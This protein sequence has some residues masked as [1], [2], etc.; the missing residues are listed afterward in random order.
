MLAAGRYNEGQKL[1]AGQ[2][3]S[4]T[5]AALEAMTRSALLCTLLA[6]APC[7]AAVP[8]PALAQTAERTSFDDQLDR[9]IDELADK[10]PKVRKRAAGRIEKLP[11]WRLTFPR[12]VRM[13]QAATR[14][15]PIIEQSDEEA[16]DDDYEGYVEDVSA[17]LVYQVSEKARNEHIPVI[18]ECFGRYNPEARS[19]ALSLLMWLQNREAAE[20]FMRLIR[21]HAPG[22]GIPS[23]HLWGWAEVPDCAEV[24]FPELL[25]YA[26]EASHEESI[27]GLLSSLADAPEFSA[28][29]LDRCTPG[30]IQ[31]YRRH[32]RRLLPAQRAGSRAAFYTKDYAAHRQAACRLLDLLAVCASNEAR[33][34]LH[35]AA[36][37]R[38]P[39]L[40]LHAATALSHLGE[41]VPGT[42]WEEIAADP[43]TRIQLFELLKARDRIQLFPARYLTQVAL[44]ESDLVRWLVEYSEAQRPPALIELVKVVSVDPDTDTGLLDYYVFQFCLDKP[45]G[46]TPTEWKAGVAGP[47]LRREQPTSSSDGTPHSSFEPIDE[48]WPE[49]HIGNLRE[50]IQEYRWRA[51]IEE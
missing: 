21:K 24:F 46:N 26:S 11:D 49:E 48:K 27:V 38:D 8:N 51:G 16:A 32:E 34:E 29:L 23:L 43:E 45:Q 37:F 15:F 7:W 33:E 13:L 3:G 10:D 2:A 6:L 31:L 50:V 28:E 42:T 9:W 18:E 41:G 44:A 40:R 35:Q 5:S 14:T 30:A 17:F 20:A 36:G 47:Y 25:E 19:Q 22:G 12:T 39:L 1:A 4:A